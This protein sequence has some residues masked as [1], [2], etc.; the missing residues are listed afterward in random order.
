M[1]QQQVVATM[2][3]LAVCSAAMGIILAGASASGGGELGN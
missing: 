1:G 2:R 3:W